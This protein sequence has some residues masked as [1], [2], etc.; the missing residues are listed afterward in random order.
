MRIVRLG[1]LIVGLWL[2]ITAIILLIL[3]QTAPRSAE[4]GVLEY[5]AAGTCV[6]RMPNG[7]RT[8]RG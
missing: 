8:F 6:Y 4:E 2:A 1:I 5:C 7:S 3:D